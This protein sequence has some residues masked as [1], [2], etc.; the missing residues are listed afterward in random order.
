MARVVRV[1]N[2]AWISA[3]VACSQGGGLDDFGADGGRDFG[4]AS[5]DGGDVDLGLGPDSGPEDSSCLPNVDDLP[6]AIQLRERGFEVLAKDLLFP[7]LLELL[8]D[9]VFVQATVI[10]G[11]IYS[12]DRHGCDLRG[13]HPVDGGPDVLSK[14]EGSSSLYWVDALGGQLYRLRAG[15]TLGTPVG[16]PRAIGAI[17]AGL[18]PSDR[19]LYW[20]DPDCALHRTSLLG[21]I[22]E[23]LTPTAGGRGL[24]VKPWGAEGAVG[25]CEGSPGVLFTWNPTTAVSRVVWSMP[26][27]EAW[28][29]RVEGSV[30][31]LAQPECDN[32]ATECRLKMPGCCPG[33]LVRVELTTGSSTTLARDEFGPPLAMAVTDRGEILYSNGVQLRWLAA[34]PESPRVIVNQPGVEAIQVDDTAAYWTS[35]RRLGDLVEGLGY[36][37]KAPLSSLR[38]E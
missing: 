26:R 19:G 36:V 23:T 5:E 22:K 2:I 20:L 11:E 14:H 4:L 21:D 29:L 8:G 32:Y 27:Q 24:G 10:E 17:F 33:S 37:V 7:T 34:G 31:Y 15:E 28:L 38:G 25:L 18:A 12:V 1:A 13:H 30:A 6:E 35:P 3:T 9:R 16:A